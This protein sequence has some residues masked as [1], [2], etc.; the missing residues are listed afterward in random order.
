MPTRFFIVAS[1]A[2]SLVA[3]ALADAAGFCLRDDFSSIYKF[4]KKPLCR[5]TTS[6]VVAVMGTVTLGAGIV[7]NGSAVV[8]FQGICFG[9]PS[10]DKVHLNMTSARADAAA[11]KQSDCSLLSWNLSGANITSVSGGS[12]RETD[13]APFFASTTLSQVPCP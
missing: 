4:T 6:T 13:G 7:C 8:G 9:A 11:G 3:P 10:E 1:L 2:L 12:E 5:S